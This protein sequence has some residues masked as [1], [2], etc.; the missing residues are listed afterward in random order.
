MF[1]RYIDLGV[2]NNSDNPAR[3]RVDRVQFLPEQNIIKVNSNEE[4]QNNQGI[5]LEESK[6]NHPLKWLDEHY[7]KLRWRFIGIKLNAFEKTDED[8]IIDKVA[9][10]EERIQ[11][12]QPSV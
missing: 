5:K 12:L 3:S 9:A 6:I 11:K 8:L 4:D 7:A 2:R 1:T 10:L